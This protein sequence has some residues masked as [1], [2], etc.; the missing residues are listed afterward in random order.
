MAQTNS[1]DIDAY[2]NVYLMPKKTLLYQKG[3]S[4]K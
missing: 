3:N 4:L 2:N 1:K